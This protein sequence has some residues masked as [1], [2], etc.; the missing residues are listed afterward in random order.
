[1]A[2]LPKRKRS[3]SRRGHRA[4]HF[5]APKATLGVCPQCRSPKL[6]HTVCKACGTYAGRQ[7]IKVAAA[8]E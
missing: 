6:S 5:A 2:P 1:M 8:A 4:S 3:K 7:V